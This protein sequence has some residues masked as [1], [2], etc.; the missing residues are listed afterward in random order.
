M[1]L[2]ALI[3]VCTLA[4]SAV[5]L[6]MLCCGLQR[7]PIQR[8]AANPPT[9]HAIPL[10]TPSHG[11]PGPYSDAPQYYA[12]P[13]NTD[14][15]SAATADWTPPPYVKEGET[16]YAPPPG[17]PPPDINGAPQV[18]PLTPV[19]TPPPGLPNAAPSQPTTPAYAPTHSGDFTGGFR[20]P[21]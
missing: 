19:Y 16:A 5:F 2:S 13:P 14:Y 4:A 1:G 3:V 9:T 10:H 6:F 11:Y 20:P 8:N 7:R 18:H 21:P 15:P 12:T 17:P